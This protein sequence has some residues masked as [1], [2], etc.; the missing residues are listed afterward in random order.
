MFK[1]KNL[2]YNL[3]SSQIIT[4]PNSWEEFV[5]LNTEVK[6]YLKWWLI[7]ENT[8]KGVSLAQF[9]PSHS[10]YTDASAWGWGATM[11]KMERKGQ[12]TIT[13]RSQ[14]SNN[15]EMLALIKAVNAFQEHLTESSLMILG[16][17]LWDSRFKIQK[18]FIWI[19][20]LSYICISTKSYINLFVCDKINGYNIVTNYFSCRTFVTLYYR[21]P[22]R[23]M[24]WSSLIVKN[25]CHYNRPTLTS[26]LS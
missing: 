24:M 17:K 15:R 6:V 19:K 22:I 7:K 14:H 9:N 23:L 12:W 25:C 2:S 11:G 1:Q 26:F 13:E 3:R 21:I 4:Q 5:P 10:L 18:R 8:M 16:S 20:C